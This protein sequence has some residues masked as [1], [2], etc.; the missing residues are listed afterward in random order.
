MNIAFCDDDLI[1]LEILMP[2]V[3]ELINKYNAYNFEFKYFS[4]TDPALLIADHK[5]FKFDIA[6]L[7]IEMPTVNGLDTGD[8][9][10]EGNES[11]FIFYVTSYSQYLSR[12]I[13][14]RVYRFIEKG[15]NDEL[16]EGIQSMFK[17]LAT[18]KANY[19]FIRKGRTYIL[20][21]MRINYFEADKNDVKI[22]TDTDVFL[23]RITIKK[24]VN[25]LPDLFCRCHS[26]YIVNSE[27]IKTIDR[28]TIVLHNNETIPIGEKYKSNVLKKFMGVF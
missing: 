23:Q 5:K 14:H 4:Y 12:S 13:K 22:V 28:E 16:A 26:S 18:R 17:D 27:K 19:V 11:V 8:A 20:P 2:T 25:N 1:L 6:F 21:V 15:D 3:K 24:L 9:L 7:D 10:F